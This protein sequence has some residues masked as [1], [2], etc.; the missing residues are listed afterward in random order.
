MSNKRNN[1]SE[2]ATI[3][4]RL[5]GQIIFVCE[6]LGP[7]CR[8]QEAPTAGPATRRGFFMRLDFFCEKKQDG[9]APVSYL[10]LHHR[11]LVWYL[12]LPWSIVTVMLNNH[13]RAFLWGPSVG[14]RE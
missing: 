5:T 9:R 14:P 1:D 6:L 10:T 7:T 13:R 4:A 2:D 12:A 11:T 3:G 8:Q